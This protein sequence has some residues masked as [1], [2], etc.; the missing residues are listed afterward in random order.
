VEAAQCLSK[1][2]SKTKVTVSM[3]PTRETGGPFNPPKPLC[4]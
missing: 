1:Y 3:I 2:P 4:R